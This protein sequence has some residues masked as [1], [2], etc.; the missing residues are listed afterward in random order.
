MSV[1][2]DV[3]SLLYDGN[4][5]T[6]DEIAKEVGV[7]PISVGFV[8]SFLR[9]YEFVEMTTMSE[10]KARIKRDKP[11]LRQAVYILKALL[12]RRRKPFEVL[13]KTFETRSALL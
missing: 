8:L 2:D 9:K 5:H 4:W 11:T 3:C 7:S 1:I 10:G 12:E 6:V 13:G